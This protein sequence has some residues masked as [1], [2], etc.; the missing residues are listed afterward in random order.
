MVVLSLFDG[1]GCGRAALER[2]GIRV[3]AYYA[4]EIDEA[5]AAIAEANYRDIIKIGDAARISYKD[6]CLMTERGCFETG[7]IDLVIGGSP[8]TDFSSAG[9]GNGMMSG[10]TEI[11]DMEQYI[12]LKSQNMP[13]GGQSYLFWEYARL[14]QEIRPDYFL[15]ENVIMQEK[16]RKTI[17]GALGCTPICI[18]S[19][20]VSAQNRKRLYWTDIPDVSPPGDRG[21]TL[22]D[23]LDRDAPKADESSCLTVQ[24]SFP[25][26]AAKYGYIPEMFNPYNLKEI[27]DKACTLSCGSMVTSSCA[28]LVFVRTP[29]GVHRVDSRIMDGI[30]PVRLRDGRYNIRKLSVREM[31]RL[32]TLPDGYTDIPSVSTAKRRK[33]VGNA[34]T[35]DVIAHILTG[36]RK[37][38]QGKRFLL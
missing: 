6:G 10:Q 4:S 2:A 7:H 17:S 27:T 11:F 23:I 29:E 25:R 12:L 9:C 35:V 19:A 32:Q 31:E 1:I 14:L 34:W 5:A 18:D 38:T 8:C 3:D 37:G 21:V 36:I 26:L 24:R 30:Y 20:L 28:V 16:W 22:A 13:F 33:A 15:F